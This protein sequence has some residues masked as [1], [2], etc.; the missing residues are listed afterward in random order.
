MSNAINGYVAHAMDTDGTIWNLGGRGWGKGPTKRFMTLAFA[1]FAGQRFK[2]PNNTVDAYLLSTETGV[3]FDY[4]PGTL[5]LAAAV[6]TMIEAGEISY[7]N[8]E[9]LARIKRT[10]WQ[11]HFLTEARDLT[12][13]EF[14]DLVHG[15]CRRTG[16]ITT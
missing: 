10:D 9:I 8:A 11:L 13:S 4:N 7:E 16:R 2:L 15:V 12:S 3:T 5:T 6:M 1:R 14:A